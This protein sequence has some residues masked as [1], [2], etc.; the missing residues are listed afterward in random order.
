MSRKADSIFLD[1]LIDKITNISKQKFTKKTEEVK[2]KIVINGGCV[3]YKNLY[4][5]F[6][7]IKNN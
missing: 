4:N 7:V 2:K 3:S 5:L 1:K 6:V